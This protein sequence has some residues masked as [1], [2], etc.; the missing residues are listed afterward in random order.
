MMMTT[1][2]TIFII[3]IV[4][5]GQCLFFRAEILRVKNKC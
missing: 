5:I 4:K 2:V 1:T 3:Y